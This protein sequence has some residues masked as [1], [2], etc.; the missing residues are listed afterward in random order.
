MTLSELDPR[1][2]NF[3]DQRAGFTFLCPHCRTTRLAC[4]TMPI[5]T[6][7]QMKIFARDLPGNGGDIVLAQHDFAWTITGSGFDELSIVPSI[8][9]SKS[10]HWHGNI[11]GGVIVGGGV[12]AP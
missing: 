3:N 12:P 11:T 5:T 10:G 8:D 6:R 9:A 1:W 7:D 2:F 4:K